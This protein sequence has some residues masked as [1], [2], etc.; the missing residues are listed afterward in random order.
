VRASAVAPEKRRL[1]RSDLYVSEVGIGANTFGPPRLDIEETRRVVH[2]ALDLGVNFIDTALVYGKGKSEE[3][4]GS[5][6][7]SRRDEMVIAT[8][9]NFSVPGDGCSIGERI[10]AQAELSLQKLQ[11]DRIDL[12][13]IHTP[14]AQAPPE[15]ILTA[16]ETLVKAGKV[17]AIGACNY[18]SWRLAEA[19]AIAHARGMSGYVTVQNYYN[20]LDRGIESEVMPWCEEY[21]ASILPYHPLAGGFLTGKYREGQPAPAGTR[22]A[23]GSAIVKHV[24]TKTNYTTLHRLEAFCREAGHSVGELAVAWLLTHPTV[25]SVITGVSNPDQLEAN[26][27]ASGWRLTAE[28]KHKVDQILTESGGHPNNPERPPYV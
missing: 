24:S 22:G 20:L 21:G 16:L 9:F 10:I 12:Y 2:A 25:G 15:E 26:V 17:I 11:T 5:A 6:L 8:K 3:F 19:A 14:S 7:S 1:G 18:A 4:L 28:E 13:Q 23:A 27:K